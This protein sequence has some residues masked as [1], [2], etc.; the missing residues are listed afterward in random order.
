MVPYF[1]I[2][3]TVIIKERGVD[4]AVLEVKNLK[5]VYASKHGGNISKALDD[6][7]FQVEKGEFVGIMGPSGAGKS[8][9]LNIIATIDQATSGEVR[10][11]GQNLSQMKDDALAMFR[12]EKLGFIFQDYNLLDTMTFHENIALPL[13]LAKE[14]PNQIEEKVKEIAKALGISQLLAK[15]PYEVSGGQRQRASAARAIISNPELIL[16]DEPTGA[17]DSKAAA[18]LLGCLEDLN[19]KRKATILLVTHDA[20][21][22]SY[23]KRILFIKD[24]NIFTEID[25]GGSRKEFFDKILS[26]LAVLGGDHRELL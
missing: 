21:T 6:V 4:M 9:L 15:Y 25:R 11:G 2:N 20:F 22:A 23:C 18:D 19:E 12:R 3:Y 14:E 1:E 10:I 13:V 17:L 16:A 5:R 8:T 24:G 26:V 7:N